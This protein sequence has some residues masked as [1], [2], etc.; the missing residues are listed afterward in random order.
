VALTE[1]A[2]RRGRRE[3]VE[4]TDRCRRERKLDADCAQ[5]APGEGANCLIINAIGDTKEA[6]SEDCSAEFVAETAS[7]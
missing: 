1:G 3:A 4:S 2:D 6:S 7:G 5:N